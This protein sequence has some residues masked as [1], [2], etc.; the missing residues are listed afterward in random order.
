MEP[1]AK[2]LSYRLFLACVTLSFIH[3]MASEK[4]WPAFADLT[5][6]L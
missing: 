6:G 4:D 2:K 3:S 1:N 5:V